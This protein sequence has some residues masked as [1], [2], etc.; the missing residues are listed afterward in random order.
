MPQIDREG[1]YKGN[2][3]D[4]GVEQKTTGTIQAAVRFLVVEAF[5]PET[6]AWE[7]WS[8]YNMEATR[9]ETIRNKDG[10]LNEIG[11]SNLI[12]HL[13]WDGASLESFQNGELKQ[14]VEFYVGMS[15][16]GNG[17]E[18]RL[19]VKWPGGE[20]KKMEASEIKALDFQ[21]G[22]KFRAMNRPAPAK[23]APSRTASRTAP[24]VAAPPAGD[25]NV[26]EPGAI[27]EEAEV[28]MAEANDPPK[29]APRTAPPRRAPA[30]PVGGH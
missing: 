12:Q 10:N 24:R 11:M 13:G 27:D 6:Q 9:Y 30:R 15:K 3:I 14:G 18:P 29:P 22:A 5:N 19:E 20:L 7:D 1:R 26:P 25:D 16:G 23:T 4:R 21:L 28:A 17:Y 2:E 8:G